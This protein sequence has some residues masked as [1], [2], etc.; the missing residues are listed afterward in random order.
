MYIVY[1]ILYSC[2]IF[3]FICFINTICYL[4][5]VGTKVNNEK[6]TIISKTIVKNKKIISIHRLYK[7]ETKK[8]QKFVTKKIILIIFD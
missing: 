7:H 3:V 2:C 8:I 6:N 4:L 1:C 5:L